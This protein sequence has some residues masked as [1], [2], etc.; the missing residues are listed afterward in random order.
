MKKICVFV[1]VIM[2]ASYG[3]AKS[4][5]P[6]VTDPNMIKSPLKVLFIGNSHTYY[7]DLDQVLKKL[8]ASPNSPV[9]IHTARIV[10]GGAT[11][12]NHWN[13]PKTVAMIK[14]VKWDMVVLQEQSTRPLNNP[15]AFFG[16]AMKFNSVIR[17]N[18]SKPVLFMMWAKRDWPKMTEKFMKVFTNL[19]QKMDAYV[20]PTGL[21]FQISLKAHPDIPLHDKDGYHSSPHGTYLAA[22]VFYTSLTGRSPIDLSARIKKITPKQA[23]YLQEAAWS[24]VQEYTRICKK[25][26]KEKRKK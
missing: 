23:R 20:A 25:Q 22:C 7:N 3:W 13:N 16:Y 15:K 21:A 12:E 18:K 14:A 10:E 19:G 17:K 5:Q 9:K 24:A 4:W 1:F 6:V 26:Q 8:S 11:L 2:F